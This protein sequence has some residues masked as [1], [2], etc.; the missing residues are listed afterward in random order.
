LNGLPRIEL[1]GEPF[2]H[3][4]HFTFI[5]E[6]TNSIDKLIVNDTRR[7][8]Y[9]RVVHWFKFDPLIL[10]NRE[11]L[12]MIQSSFLF[13]PCANI[14]SMSTK[15]INFLVL[16][17]ICN[18]KVWPF[19]VHIFAHVFLNNIS[20]F[21]IFS[22]FELPSQSGYLIILIATSKDNALLTDCNCT[23][24]CWDHIVYLKGG[25]GFLNHI[26]EQDVFR[27]FFEVMKNCW[28]YVAIL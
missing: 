12:T 8:V 18:C 26:I 15:S 2:N 27:I 3:L 14:T 24:G 25:M 9:L 1:N 19:L 5:G 16:I 28:V 21:L 11:L 17:I 4:S 10:L 20:F 23:A 13:Y 22:K 7:H 6:S